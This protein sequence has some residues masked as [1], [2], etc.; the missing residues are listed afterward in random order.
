MAVRISLKKKIK[1]FLKKPYLQHSDFFTIFK[2]IPNMTFK[3]NLIAAALLLTFS[4]ATFAQ[5]EPAKPAKK[6][7]AKK[8]KPAT[9]TTKKVE[10]HH[11][12]KAK[13]ETKK[14]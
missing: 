4:A 7:K 10:H 1:N 13:E 8:E 6:E 12:K 9:D 5:T 11:P 2:K 14:G 3:K